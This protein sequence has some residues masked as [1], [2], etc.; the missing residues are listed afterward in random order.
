MVQC[1]GSLSVVD[2]FLQLVKEEWLESSSDNQPFSPMPRDSR[3]RLPV[4]YVVL[5][6][7][8]EHR[9]FRDYACISTP[10]RKLLLSAPRRFRSL[11]VAGLSAWQRP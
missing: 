1:R 4:L 6:T 10:E 9:N 3:T 2:S 7:A 5:C 11:Q 8:W